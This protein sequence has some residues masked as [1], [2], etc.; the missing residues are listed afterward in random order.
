MELKP[1]EI[2]LGTLEQKDTAEV[3]WALRSF[4]NSAKKH[5]SQLSNKE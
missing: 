2:R 4:T 5:R 3:E 1:Y